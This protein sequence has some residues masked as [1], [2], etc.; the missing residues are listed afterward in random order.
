VALAF[1]PEPDIVSLDRPSHLVGVRAMAPVTRKA[2]RRVILRDE[3]QRV[4]GSGD[5]EDDGLA[6]IE[7][8]TADLADPGAGE[9][10]ASLDGATEPVA[11]VSHSIERHARAEIAIENARVEGDPEDGIPLAVHVTS[12]RGDVPSGAVEVVL[13]DRSVGAARVH[14]GR[15]VV[16]ARFGA[17]RTSA[18]TA[19]LRYLPDTPWWEP[20][21]SPT[22]LMHLRAPSPWRRAPLLLLA[23]TLM[24][25]VMRG[26]LLAALRS[27]RGMTKE[28]GP[29]PLVREQ[30]EVV[31]MRE[32]SSDWVGI[33]V[34]AHDRD[35][36]A[37]ATVS[38]V[39]PAFPGT[40][41]SAT[42]AAVATTTGPDGRFVLPSAPLG[43]EALLRVET[44]YYATFEQ[45]LPPPS[46]L[47]IPL[48]SRRRRLLDRLVQ[49]A[50]REW[51]P[52]GLRE[53]TPADVV[54]RAS[55]DA[56]LGDPVKRDRVTRVKSW[57]RTL[58]STVFGS[59]PVD[60]DAEQNVL[61]RE[62]A[63][64][65]SY[66][67]PARRAERTGGK[68]SESPFRGGE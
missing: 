35:P 13:G 40:A 44:L 39:V 43:G 51:G 36:I 48:V 46:E 2:D 50:Q 58:E 33:V 34:D 19:S 38:I 61:S 23:V 20:G 63:L 60:G 22:V 1:D 49:W 4:V 62:P 45:P 29:Q 7:L 57:A 21:T 41:R 14:A 47:T 67:D 15:A 3:R 32:K 68:K 42:G 31:R 24:A 9:I 25:W 64:P 59:A 55:T 27:G 56:A 65:G 16:V 53:P 66:E 18:V 28:R 8:R 26:P 52:S 30:L 10:S 17:G 37:L 11:R 6:R 54:A 5:L 12:S